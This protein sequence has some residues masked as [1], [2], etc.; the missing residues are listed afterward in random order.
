MVWVLPDEVWPY[1]KMVQLKPAR[2]CST[3]GLPA[4]ASCPAAVT[5]R[6]LCTL[7]LA[8]KVHAGFEVIPWERCTHRQSWAPAKMSSCVDP[9][10]DTWL[11]ANWCVRCTLSRVPST[12]IP[13]GVCLRL[14]APIAHKLRVQNWSMPLVTSMSLRRKDGC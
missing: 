11:K 7:S 13:V 5:S 3:A 9:G 4:T 10:P 6:L 2:Q 1:A 8:S 12:V 14:P